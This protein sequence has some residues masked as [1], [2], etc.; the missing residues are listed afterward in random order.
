[1]DFTSLLIVI[2]GLGTAAVIAVILIY[3]GALG[4]TRAWGK[5]AHRHSAHHAH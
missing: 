5:F 1:M 3:A 2:V 4:L